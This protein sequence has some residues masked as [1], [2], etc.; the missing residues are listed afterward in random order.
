M[1]A[2]DNKSA[3]P[4]SPHIQIYKPIINMIMSIVHRIT[5]AA[6]YVGTLL[7]AWW[8]VAVAVGPEAYATASS[9]LGSWFGRLVL[10]G[11]CWALMHHMFGGVRHLIWDTGRGFDLATVD[12]MAWGTLIA[13]LGA[14]ALICLVAFTRSTGGITV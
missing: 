9:V 7:L 6:L 3:R 1:A 2:S 8:L 14:T 10:I 12:R 13:S 5:G 11:Y 4:L